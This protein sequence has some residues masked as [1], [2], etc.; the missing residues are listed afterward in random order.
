MTAAALPAFRRIKALR[1]PKAALLLKPAKDAGEG[2]RRL[3]RKD[4]RILMENQYEG[5]TAPAKAAVMPPDM[6]KAICIYGAACQAGCAIIDAGRHPWG[7]EPRGYL[8]ILARKPTR[9]GI[10]WFVVLM[11][12]S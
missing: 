7:G 4:C 9:V 3:G 10:S 12:S 11:Q 5:G 6:G 2:W 8:K 1:S